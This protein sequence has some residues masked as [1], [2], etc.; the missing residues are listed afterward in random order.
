M[1]PAQLKVKVRT[2]LSLVCS[3]IEESTDINYSPVKLIL[4]CLL[5]KFTTLVP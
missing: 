2:Q 5:S 3:L 4:L 1:G